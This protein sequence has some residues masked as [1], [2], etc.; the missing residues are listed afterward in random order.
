[1]TVKELRCVHSSI[2]HTKEL[3]EQLACEDYPYTAFE[4]ETLRDMFYQLNDM[5]IE[6][7]KRIDAKEE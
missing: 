7:N 1:M 4:D 3:I 5:C 6:I 2:W